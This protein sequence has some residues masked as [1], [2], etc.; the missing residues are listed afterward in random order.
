MK[1]FI[2][3]ILLVFILGCVT[4]CATTTFTKTN[5]DSNGKVTSTTDVTM[6]RPILASTSASW[7]DLTGNINSASSVSLEQMVASML[8]GYLASQ[9]VGATSATPAV[10]K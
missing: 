3:L 4:S 1:K 2:W 6:K 9:T 5:Y 8:A 10:V 7:T